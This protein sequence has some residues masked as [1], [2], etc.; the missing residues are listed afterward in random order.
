MKLLICISGDGGGS[1]GPEGVYW[2]LVK[3]LDSTIYHVFPYET[4]PGSIK[5]NSEPICQE[6]LRCHMIYDDIFLIGWSLGTATCVE[7]ANNVSSVVKISGIIM[8]APV[9]HYMTK[10]G[11]LNVPM[12]FI[13]GKNDKVAPYINS[14]ILYGMKNSPKLIT[15][16]EQCDHL[17]TNNGNSLIIDIMK[18]VEAFKSQHHVV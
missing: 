10:F 5:K 9:V 8:L 14:A 2:Q 7:I 11:H 15:L 13:H 3:Q 16:Y 6:L 12:G 1:M 17:F 18:M 4:I